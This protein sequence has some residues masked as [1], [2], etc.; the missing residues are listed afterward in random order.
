MK[1]KK[2][3]KPVTKEIILPNLMQLEAVSVTEN[4]DADAKAV[5]Q[6][7]FDIDSDE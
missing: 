1:K 6:N 3:Q 7:Y 2:Y 4:G 5:N